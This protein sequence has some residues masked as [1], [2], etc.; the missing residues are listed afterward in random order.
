MTIFTQAL[1]LA[2]IAAV[3]AVPAFFIF[4]KM[5]EAWLQD[6][7]FD[8]NADNVRW[9]KRLKPYHIAIFAV[10]YAV[11]VF[12]SAYFY[13]DFLCFKHILRIT[14]LFLALPGFT[15]IVM[16]DSL[17][18]IIPDHII[19]LNTALALLYFASDFVDGNIWI[20]SDAPWY[21]YVINRVGAALLGAGGLFLI[22]FISSMIA[23]TEAMGMGDVKL[24]V[25]C[26]LLCGLRGLIF[27][28]FIAFITAA[29]VAI[30][31]LIR[32]RKRIA[33]EEREIRESPDP[34]K[35]RKILAK[36]KREMHFADDPDYLAFGPF[37]VLGTVLFLLYEPYFFDFFSTH[38][39]PAFGRV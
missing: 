3:M 23:K 17:N 20:A 30:P 2:L 31:L 1:I 25:P 18:R 21:T 29:V 10:I 32:K 19:V 26:G 38:I 34:A 39:A 13:P 7:G 22:G 33:R 5:P 16:S 15:I 28:V 36:K 9:S 8:P 6:Y 37:L 12:I 11:V 14:A 4:N 35:A 24:L 27:M